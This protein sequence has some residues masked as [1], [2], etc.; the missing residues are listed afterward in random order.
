[1]SLRVRPRQWHVLNRNL[2]ASLTGF[3]GEATAKKAVDEVWR[4]TRHVSML[5][6]GIAYVVPI[7]PALSRFLLLAVGRA[8]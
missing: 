8:P 2:L 1:M 3:L 4:V 7:S 5:T 6:V